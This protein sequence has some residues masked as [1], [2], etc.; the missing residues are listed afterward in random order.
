ML[1]QWQIFY[2]DFNSESNDYKLEMNILFKSTGLG[3]K[4]G[5]VWPGIGIFPICCHNGKYEHIK[6]NLIMFK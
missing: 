1:C 6:K 3:S 4:D 5:V 2:G